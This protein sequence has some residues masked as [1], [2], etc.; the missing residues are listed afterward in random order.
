MLKGIAWNI[1]SFYIET[2]YFCL[3]ELFEIEQFRHL[4][5]CK[6]K[7]ILMLN[8]IVWNRTVDTYKNRLCINNGWCSTKP[9]LTKPYQ[10]WQDQPIDWIGLHRPLVLQSKGRSWMLRVTKPLW[11]RNRRL[12]NLK[13]SVVIHGEQV[14]SLGRWESSAEM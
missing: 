13:D 2:E 4:T 9:N 1:T 7:S 14:N 12:W 6:Q 5:V 10:I 11:R 8:R 3:T